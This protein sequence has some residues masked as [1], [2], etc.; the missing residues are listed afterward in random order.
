VSGVAAA[1]GLQRRLRVR[2]SREVVAAGERRR[3]RVGP[4]A[5][6]QTETI[7]GGGGRRFGPAAQAQTETITGGGG[8]R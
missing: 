2:R 1:S 6:A 3:G 4:A 7:T 8:R 5:Q